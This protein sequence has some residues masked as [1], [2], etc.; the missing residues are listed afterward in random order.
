MSEPRRERDAPQPTLP[1]P[2]RTA[3]LLIRPVPGDHLGL[4]FDKFLRRDRAN[5]WS[6]KADFRLKAVQAYCGTHQSPACAEA[7]AR[8]AHGATPLSLRDD[9]PA[10]ANG[11]LLA[12][13][14]AATTG[15]LLVDYGRASAHEFA[16]SFHHT[17][18]AP[19]IPGS[20]LKGLTRAL[21]EEE[22]ADTRFLGTGPSPSSQG[23]R[24]E[25]EFL[26]ALPSGGR[27]TLA[28]DVL[29]PHYGPW[30]RGEEPPADWLAPV[31]HT[32]ITVAQTTFTFDVIGRDAPTLRTAA[33]A[34]LRGL[35]ELGVGAKRAAGYGYFKE[36]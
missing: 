9:R 8:R 24:G 6:L 30:Y 32:F 3:G 29:N 27:F 15:R 10:P 36:A 18:G 22:G 17:Y 20:A 16:L 19:R 34:L 35:T 5:E 14:Q 2:A 11:F 13:F 23:Q 26:D 25:V 7:L 33:R 28:A 4:W 1:L 31:P 21:L 12:R